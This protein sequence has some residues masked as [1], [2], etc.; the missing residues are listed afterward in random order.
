M[1]LNVLFEKR[2]PTFLTHLTYHMNYIQADGNQTQESFCSLV[3]VRWNLAPL[4]YWG[5]LLLLLFCFLQ[6]GILVP[7]PG[8]KPVPPQW[9]HSLNHWTTC[10]V[11]KLEGFDSF[12][13]K[14]VDA[15]PPWSAVFI[16]PS[17]A[18]LWLSAP[19]NPTW[20]YSFVP[21]D[22]SIL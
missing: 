11:P 7:S 5:F 14:K 1:C 17:L 22:Q 8:I 2:N 18:S 21:P 6:C 10:K 13:L 20:G 15:I 12:K 9:K 4:G 3:Y 16:R 19:S